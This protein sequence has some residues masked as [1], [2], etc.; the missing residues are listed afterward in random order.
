[1]VVF[2]GG[3]AG[4]GVGYV[5]M[6]KDK[7]KY[8]L[9]AQGVLLAG[10][11]AAMTLTGSVPLLA[12]LSLLNGIARGFWP[13]L[14]TVPF[15]LPGIRPREVAVA[16]ALTYR[17]AMLMTA[18]AYLDGARILKQEQRY[19]PAA[20]L[21]RQTLM[22]TN[23][24]WRTSFMLGGIM[25][26]QGLYQEALKYF[27]KDERENPW[28]A[29][30]ILHQAKAHRELAKQLQRAG[31]VE[32]AVVQYHQADAQC[33]R[34]LRLVP[35]YPEAAVTIASLAYFRANDARKTGRQDE[36]QQHLRHA[37]VWLNYA[38]AFFPRNAEALKLQGFVEIMDEK[39]IPARD[40][41]KRYIRVK[42][43][44]SNMDY[45]LRTLQADLPRLLQG[46]KPK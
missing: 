27:E 12:A 35:N 23:A 25:Y 37:R 38:L 14:Y 33:R 20:Y 39:W 26:G 24:P 31:S 19:A 30:A 7:R 41:W 36:M 3:F 18:Q 5:V 44:D 43:G 15:H 46:G 22:I 13:I 32:E 9:Q 45:R 11:Y 6:A 34:A 29:D 28:G 2:V 1:M 4:L 8:I 21:A 10:S 42:P 40:A 16:L 17:P